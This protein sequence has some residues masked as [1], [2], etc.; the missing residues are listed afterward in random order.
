M[1][2]RHRIALNYCLKERELVDW[3][4]N[5]DKIYF[6]NDIGRNISDYV[7]N[8][9]LLCALVTHKFPSELTA[10]TL[11]DILWEHKHARHSNILLLKQYLTHYMQ[12]VDSHRERQQQLEEWKIEMEKLQSNTDITHFYRLVRGLD[13][14]LRDPHQSV[15]CGTHHAYTTL[16]PNQRNSLVCA[17][18]KE[19]AHGSP[20]RLRFP[21]IV[22]PLKRHCGRESATVF[23]EVTLARSTSIDTSSLDRSSDHEISVEASQKPYPRQGSRF[24]S[25][26]DGSKIPRIEPAMQSQIEKSPVRHSFVN[27]KDAKKKYGNLR[28]SNALSAL[29]SRFGFPNQIKSFEGILELEDDDDTASSSSIGEENA[30]RPN[31]SHKRPRALAVLDPQRKDEEQARREQKQSFRQ[32]ETANHDC[33]QESVVPYGD[34]A[35]LDHAE[36]T[37]QSTFDG[38]HACTASLTITL[39]REGKLAEAVYTDL[40]KDNAR[41]RMKMEHLDSEINYM[42]HLLTDVEKTVQRWQDDRADKLQTPSNEIVRQ[43]DS[44]RVLVESIENIIRV[45]RKTSSFKD[46]SIRS[47]RTSFSL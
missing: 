22:S 12:T 17:S 8:G 11:S 40:R 15:S 10:K 28:G 16:I 32:R 37:S 6:P 7:H 46:E 4:V 35:Q 33:F 41:L 13:T 2:H 45:P 24:F 18:T 27:T 21:S 31:I 19:P 23:T 43:A 1:M 14:I 26:T 34:N 3:V 9:A 47:I 36:N 20:S 39:Q 30:Y 42:Y 44:T 29:R 25:K 38:E 5:Q